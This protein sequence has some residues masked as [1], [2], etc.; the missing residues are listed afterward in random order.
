[1]HIAF[2]DATPAPLAA[3]RAAKELGHEV[4]FIESDNPFYAPT[5][6]NRATIALADHLL[7]G[8]STCDPDAVTAALD[9]CHGESPIDVVTSQHEMAARAVAIA[10]QRLGLR[11]TSPE[12]VLTARRKD[13]C[14]EALR[15]AGLA[16]AQ[17]ALASDEAGVLA[18]AARIG[19]P[20][21]LK[22]PAGTDSRLT[23]VVTSPAEASA[24]CAQMLSGLDQ[25]PPGWREQFSEGVL[26]EEL[27]V[28]TL[29]SVEIG[30]RDGTFFPFCLSGR[31][32]WQ[33]NEVVE[34]GA[35]IPGLPEPQASRC[36]RYA[37]EVCRAIGLDLGVFH[38]EIMLTDRGPVLIEANPRIMGG[39]MPTIYRL[40]TGAEIYGSLVRILTGAPD[41]PL[42]G[43]FD[44]CTG[45]HRVAAAEAGRI[46][47]R[48]ALDFLDRHP[49]VLRVFGFDD[50]G[51]AAGQPV[52]PGQTVARFILRETSHRSLVATAEELLREAQTVLGIRLMI[53]EKS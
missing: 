24:G 29:V 23:F 35:Y 8:V 49:A 45:A 17:F 44:G 47:P 20:V 27:L 18:A 37:E 51:T 22:P 40:A 41:V 32:R 3:I 25:V 43:T 21:V 9:K 13:L 15:A 42:P 31:I 5:P 36:V 7:T 30:A 39:A 38:L 4:T 53:G 16:H 11:G 48:A 28:G 46:D 26:I 14:R 10:S 33:E 34:L 52:H 50:F 6:E 12:G 19:Y 1:M 2:V